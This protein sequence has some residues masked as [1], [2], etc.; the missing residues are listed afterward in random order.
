MSSSPFL[1]C[2]RPAAI[3]AYINEPL[4]QL[5]DEVDVIVTETTVRE[6]PPVNGDGPALDGDGEI[7]A[8]EIDMRE[9][10]SLERTTVSAWKTLLLGAPNPRSL[11]LTATTLLINAILVAMVADRLYHEHYYTGEDLSFVR[12][13][14]VSDTEAKLL[15]REPDQAKMPVTIRVRMKDARASFR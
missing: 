13:G 8:E 2:T 14:Y 12:V 1:L 15:I 4:Y 6:D 10:L 7:V 9:T 5:V 11:L 3:S